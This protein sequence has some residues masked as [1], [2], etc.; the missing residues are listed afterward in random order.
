MPLIMKVPRIKGGDDPT[1]IVGFEVERMI[2]PALRGPH[3]PRFVARGDF[4]AQPYIVM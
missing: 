4:T 1:T 3:V 2:L